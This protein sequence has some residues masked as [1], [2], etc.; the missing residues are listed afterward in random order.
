MLRNIYIHIPFCLKKCDYCDFYSIVAGESE[1]DVYLKC[2]E[3]E[4]KL[5]SKSLSEKGYFYVDT[6][7]VGGGTPTV[8]D[9][10][11]LEAFLEL[12]KRYFVFRNSYEFTFEANPGTVSFNKLRLLKRYGVNRLSVGVQSFID[13]ELRILG[14]IHDVDAALVFL[15]LSKELGFESINV[16]LIYAI[17][18]QTIKSFKKSL[19]VAV[20]FDVNHISC[21]ELT[22]NEDL[23]LYQKIC[24]GLIPQKPDAVEFFL[25]AHR[26]LVKRYKFFHYEISNYAK[27]LEHICR[28]NLNYWMYGSY[29]GLGPSAAGYVNSVRYTNVSDFKDYCFMLDKGRLPIGLKES[30][31][32]DK[33]AEEE[34][35]L[36]MRT[37]WG[38]KIADFIKKY[39]ILGEA[40]IKRALEYKDT[41]F[42]ELKEGFIRFT[43]KG[44]LVS[45]ELLCRII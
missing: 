18:T 23:P 26:F 28:H 13:E 30:I 14:R 15:R 3:K 6:V 40:I 12:I 20:S 9:E 41:D 43:L 22:L 45:N 21:Y 29:L 7:Y 27:G 10:K 5:W 19:E 31:S 2:L 24:C 44:M 35:M 39:S 4:I 11:R 37:M 8:L 32:I 33:M 42:L 17:P 16:D 25:F 38:V 1:Y 36:K 34:F